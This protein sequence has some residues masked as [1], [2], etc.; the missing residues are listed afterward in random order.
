M[1]AT[2]IRKLI[3]EPALRVT[4]LWS[5]E[6]E[7]LVYGSGWV[8]SG[9]DAIKQHGGPAL[10]FFQCEPATF[11][12][13]CTWLRYGPNRVL[14]EHLLDACYYVSM[15]VD[16]MVLAHNIKF[17]ALICRIHYLRKSE[18]LPSLKVGNPGLAFA[19]YHSKNY[20]CGGKANVERN[21]LVFQQIIDGKL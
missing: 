8:E 5:L 15:P 6:S 13:V 10:G 21:A 4:D 18:P 2:E 3:I 1:L 9:Y 20:N 16:P 14:R 17:A 7:I 12:D 19:K 11:S